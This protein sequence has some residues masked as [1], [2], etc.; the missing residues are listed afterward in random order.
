LTHINLQQQGT[1]VLEQPEVAQ[2]LN[3]TTEQLAKIKEIQE[4]SSEE[5][6]ALFRKQMEEIRKAAE[7]KVTSVFTPDQL[8]KWNEARGEPFTGEIVIPRFGGGPPRGT[9]PGEQSARPTSDAPKTD[10]VSGPNGRPTGNTKAPAKTATPKKTTT[11]P[12][13]TTTKKAPE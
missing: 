3:L 12:K 9:S 7:K 8:A 1:R 4:A 13:K 11:T 10:S 2:Q 5:V 6:S